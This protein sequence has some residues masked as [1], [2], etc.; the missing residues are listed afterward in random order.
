MRISHE[1]FADFVLQFGATRLSA[2]CAGERHTPETPVAME[3]VMTKDQWIREARARGGN[4]P[5]LLI[6]YGLIVATM[7]LTASSMT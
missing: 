2:D 1:F 6:V 5:A 3:A 4:L 7:V